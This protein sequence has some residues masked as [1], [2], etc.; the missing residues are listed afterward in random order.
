MPGPLFPGIF[1][2]HFCALFRRDGFLAF[3]PDP[4]RPAE[5][6]GDEQ[7]GAGRDGPSQ[8]LQPLLPCIA[9]PLRRRDRV[10]QCRLR[11]V[12]GRQQRQPQIEVPF[13]QALEA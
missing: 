2:G 12:I 6:H 5:E 4:P 7:R 9:F 3:Q 1:L 10:P 8:G 13:A 11:R